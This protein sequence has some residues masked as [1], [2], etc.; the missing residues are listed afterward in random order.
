VP[1]H[2]TIGDY[3]FDQ[4]AEAYDL[5]MQAETDHDRFYQL[6][7]MFSAVISIQRDTINEVKSLRTYAEQIAAGV[8][9]NPSKG[10]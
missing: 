1:E 2:N 5:F 6:T 9:P 3:L 8:S 7:K 4:Y 10:E